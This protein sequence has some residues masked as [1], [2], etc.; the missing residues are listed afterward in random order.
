M[1]SKVQRLMEE[2]CSKEVKFGE[3]WL[4]LE[5]PMAHIFCG[6]CECKMEKEPWCKNMEDWITEYYK[7]KARN[8]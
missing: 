4:C 2:K 6:G 3:I 1:E 7:D 8:G 5:F